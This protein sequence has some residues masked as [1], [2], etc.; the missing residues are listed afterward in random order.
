MG[1]SLDDPY[2]PKNKPKKVGD[3]WFR[4]LVLLH[5]KDSITVQVSTESG[6]TTME[7]AG[8][9]LSVPYNRRN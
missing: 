1:H 9:F 6:C 3:R 4:P 2:K 5:H 8:V 7:N